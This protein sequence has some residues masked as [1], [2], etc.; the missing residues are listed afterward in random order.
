MGSVSNV[1]EL[2]CH[3]RFL[4]LLS[5][6]LVVFLLLVSLDLFLFLFGFLSLAKTLTRACSLFLGLLL[7]IG[8]LF[9]SLVRT[10]SIALLFPDL[11]P[12]ITGAILCTL[13]LARS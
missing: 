11:L 4:A 1:T 10:L 13:S 12:H 5:V 9:L 2:R 7:S 3:V 6:F 8:S